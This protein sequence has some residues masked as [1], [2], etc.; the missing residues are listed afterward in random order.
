[1]L[2]ERTCAVVIPTKD[3]PEK[4][5]RCLEAIDRART[6]RFPVYV[7][8][9]SREELR[10]EVESVVSKYSYVRLISH[11]GENA[12]AA[13]NV[14]A[15][16]AEEDLLISVDDDVYVESDAL[17]AL[18]AAYQSA[19]GLRVVAGTVSWA[20]TWSRPIKMRAIGYGR[21]VVGSEEPDFLLSTLLMY[22]RRFALTW[23]WNDRTDTSED[24]FMGALWRAKSVD[25]LFEPRARAVHDCEHVTYG[26][27]HQR[28]HI[29]TNLFDS[30]IAERDLSRA[31]AY[32]FLGFL[33]GLKRYGRTPQDFTSYVGAWILGHRDLVCDWN[34]L[35]EL[36]SAE[37]PRTTRI[38]KGRMNRPSP[39]KVSV[40]VPTWR[41]PTQLEAC[42]R[43]MERLSGGPDELIVV[44]RLEDKAAAEVIRRRSKATPI[45]EVVIA[46]PG[47]LAALRGGVLRARGDIIAFTDD[48]AVPRADWIERLVGHFDD[49]T[50][51]GVGGRDVF[52][53]EPSDEELTRR[54]GLIGRWGRVI[55]NHHRGEGP[56]RPVDVVKGVNM[57]FRREA[58]AIPEGLRGAG[59]QVHNEIA[60][61]GWARAQGWRVIYDPAIVVDHYLGLRFDADRRHRPEPSAIEDAAYNLVLALLTA[62]PNLYWRRAA[63]GLLIGG[64]AAP[65]PI[66]VLLGLLQAQGG[67]AR[68]LGPSLRGQWQ[69][70]RDFRQGTRLRPIR[71]WDLSPPVGDPSYVVRLRAGQADVNDAVS[72]T[73]AV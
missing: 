8:D 57:A 12:A 22:P 37:V 40:V 44:R 3:R 52:Q 67:L 64:R 17:D 32:E 15:R 73:E 39:L 25:L 7:C 63:F 56:P 9:S 45:S 42:L 33:A 72:G 21:H 14:C 61:C 28:S 36:V 34:Y 31:F 66:R 53:G 27:H 41:R 5:A 16:A 19:S 1:M 10:R 48:D 4:L 18:Y 30:L 47:L 11:S 13:R 68:R 29:Y 50:V 69:A 26:A 38:A 54:V 62:Q 58:L 46:E 51:G 65:G 2:R 60:I 23:P 71:V 24:R 43:G 35:K 20:G 49:P 70:L 6:R 55:G 59:A